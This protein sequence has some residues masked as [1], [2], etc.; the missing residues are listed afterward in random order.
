[1]DFNN[2][3]NYTPNNSEFNSS[4]DFMSATPGDNH[5][6]DVRSTSSK[7]SGL[8]IASL[9]LGIASLVF[10]CFWYVTIAT[11]VTGLILGVIGLRKTPPEAQTM[12][13]V[14]VILSAV[15]LA[16]S[17]IMM[18]LLIVACVANPYFM[19]DLFYELDLY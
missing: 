6:F 9:I 8:T 15:A 14:G 17:F 4:S 2:D 16:L 1:M 13:K 19:E 3:T 11:S 5:G 18:I 7:P 10:C 12:G